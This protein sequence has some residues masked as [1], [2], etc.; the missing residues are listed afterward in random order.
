MRANQFFRRKIGTR[1]DEPFA[2]QNDA[3]FEPTG[4]WD[5]SRHHKHV[6]NY[7]FVGLASLSILPRDAF[8]MVEAFEADN[9]RVCQQADVGRLADS[10]NKVF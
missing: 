2:V 7:P 4:V 10:T 8:E 3:A 9:F 6:R 1:L 5:R